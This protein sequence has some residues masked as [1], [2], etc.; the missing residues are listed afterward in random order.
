M[1]PIRVFDLKNIAVLNDY[2]LMVF[3]HA[4]FRLG[5]NKERISNK[6][7][8]RLGF[9]S[10]LRTLLTP[11]PFPL[12]V[13]PP[14]RPRST[15]SPF[16]YLARERILY[17]LGRVDPGSLYLPVTSMTIVTRVLRVPG[18]PS[19]LHA[20]LEVRIPRLVYRIRFFMSSL[21]H[22]YPH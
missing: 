18:V 20:V 14:H 15:P 6:W 19:V 7:E 2:P 22:N 16:S 10:R 11:P 17:I 3:L 9:N 8:R 1:I 21:A 13:C 5:H 12:P 4:R